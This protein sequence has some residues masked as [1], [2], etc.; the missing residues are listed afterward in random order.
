MA[1]RMYLASAAIVL[2]VQST[3]WAADSIDV[4]GI[5]K[6]SAEALSG[7]EETSVQEMAAEPRFHSAMDPEVR[8]KLEAGLEIAFVRLREID[9]CSD[10]FSRLGVDGIEMLRSGHFLQVNNHYREV[11]ICGRNGAVRS[12]GGR[13]FAYT[14]VGGSLIWICR[15]VAR[16]SDEVSAVIVIHEALHHAG[17]TEWPSDRLAMTS[18]EI[19]RMVKRA[20]KF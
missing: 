16:V 10:L 5:A 19:T 2:C 4:A 14:R 1:A 20:C 13:N 7:V 8:A 17:L 9:A 12:E 18:K 3:V 11:R 6:A 15:H